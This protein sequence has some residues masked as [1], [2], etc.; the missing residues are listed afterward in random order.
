M[1]IINGV[2]D[3]KGVIGMK[4]KLGTMMGI[5]AFMSLAILGMHLLSTKPSSVENSS[6]NEIEITNDDVPLSPYA[7]MRIS[8]NEYDYQIIP[9]KYNTGCDDSLI[10]TI[11]DTPGEYN[12]ITISQYGT[13]GL[14][15]YMKENMPETIIFE[16]YDFTGDD[17]ILTKEGQMQS[18]REIIFINCKF[19]SF[20]ITDI[21]ETNVNHYFE[22]C[23]FIHFA[24]SNS[25]FERCYF[26]DGAQ[27]DGINPYRNC[28]FNNC[29]IANLV[30]R[31]EAGEG[32]H[33][34]G[35]QVFGD[36][37]SYALDNVNIH[38]SNCRF[39]VPNIPYTSAAGI[40]NCP[41]TFTMRYSNASDISF[42]DCIVNGGTYYSI[43]LYS[44]EFSFT[45]VFF[46]NVKV[47]GS[48][49]S[50]NVIG[51]EPLEATLVNV[52]D[53]EYLYAA[54]VWRDYQG[55]HVS[56]TNDTNQE[57][58][59][60]IITS[61]GEYEEVIPACPVSYYIPVDSMDY[62]DF[63]FDL[64]ICV[65]DAEWIVC[66]DATNG[67]MEQIRFE[68]WSNEDVY[69]DMLLF[70]QKQEEE[71]Q[72]DIFGGIENGDSGVVQSGLCG[73]DVEYELTSDGCLHLY[74]SGATYSYNSNKPAPWYE[75]REQIYSIEIS[76]GITSIGTRLFA[77]CTNIQEIEIP[78]SVVQIGGN[79]FIKAKN[80]EKLVL[81]N[82]LEKID[83]YAFASTAISS[84]T[85]MGTVEQW[86]E[87]SIGIK[88]DVLQTAT[89]EFCEVATSQILQTGICGEKAFWDYYTD[90]VLVISGEGATDNYNS[91]N[92]APWGAL[93]TDIVCVI[94]EE[95]IT[96]IGSQAM[97][98]CSNLE[99]VILADSVEVINS[100]AFIKCASLTT[101]T[102]GSGISN[103][104]RYAFAGTNVTTLYYN[105]SENEWLQIEIAEKNDPITSANIFFLED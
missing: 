67:E 35:F 25:T 1:H 18:N 52:G 64:D 13:K 42:R 33:V 100:N 103:I 36:S 83:K 98:M 66:F 49:K 97:S 47:G 50:A 78:E 102:F 92:V 20:R 51:D 45:D 95:G 44:G 19:A 101:V 57:R 30:Q 93:R 105:G 4:K 10:T 26:G 68:N 96:T 14:A 73:D 71:N 72:T 94:V 82:G 17:F 63:P 61:N 99:S 40:L 8:P 56:V 104:N 43:M 3:I 31:S 6:E 85:Y 46:E 11:V 16:N 34:D 48:R 53:T 76:E 79:A 15:I 90:G 21:G 41:I 84:I 75:I 69:L 62:V 87:V 60:K 65:E 9:D 27:G 28:T 59:L 24:G 7:T 74:G 12:G 37:S 32:N 80:L 5:L 91:T 70:E 2:Y 39:E 55:V 86:D 77:E 88:N 58:L 22:K 29:M 23:S 54:S 38:L 81:Y 89:I